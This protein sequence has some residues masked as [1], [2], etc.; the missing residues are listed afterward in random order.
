MGPEEKI[1]KQRYLRRSRSGKY[2]MSIV[3]NQISR[4]KRFLQNSFNFKELINIII[5]LMFK[6]K[7]S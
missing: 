5:L 7:P 2:F 3:V 4:N 6:N 1:E